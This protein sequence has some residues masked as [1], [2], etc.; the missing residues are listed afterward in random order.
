MSRC[1]WT[2]AIL[3]LSCPAQFVSGRLVAS[4]ILVASLFFL[5]FNCGVAS[6]QDASAL[7]HF[8][9]HI[10]PL[11]I[12]QCIECHGPDRQ[13]SGLRL[14]SREGWMKGGERGPAITPGDPTVSLLFSRNKARRS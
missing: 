9:L 3:A 6:G 8:E 11:L 12:A 14:D 10:R 7:D 1:R 4:F 5:L 2:F 13:E